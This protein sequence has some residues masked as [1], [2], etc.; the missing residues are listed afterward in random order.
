MLQE[1]EITEK[2]KKV[3][4]AGCRC[5]KGNLKKAAMYRL[6]R[7]QETIHTGKAQRSTDTD[8]KTQRVRCFV[9]VFQGN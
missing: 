8:P 7:E 9:Y 4:V 2:K 3:R 6:V 1:F 5:V